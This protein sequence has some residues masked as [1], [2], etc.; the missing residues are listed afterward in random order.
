MNLMKKKEKMII[1][2]EW[3]VKEYKK[4]IMKNVNIIILLRFKGN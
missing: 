2:L 3:M 1:R 4:S